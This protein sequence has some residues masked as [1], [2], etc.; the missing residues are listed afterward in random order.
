MKFP[1]LTAALLLP[2]PLPAALPLTGTGSHVESFDSLPSASTQEWIDNAPLPN[3]YLHRSNAAAPFPVTL[4]INDNQPASP[5]VAGIYSLGSTGST[6]RALGSAPTGTLGEVALILV[7]E[8]AG[9]LPLQITQIVWHAEKWREN[10]TAGI[11]ERIDFSWQKSLDEFSLISSFAGGWN[12][13]DNLSVTVPHS[14]I[15]A[16][17]QD[18]GLVFPVSQAPETPMVLE[19]GEYA[20]LRWLNLNESGSDAYLGIDNVGL[21][22][23]TVNGAIV[24]GPQNLTRETKGTPGPGDDTFSFT[25]PVTGIGSVSPAGWILAAPLPAGWTGPAGGAYGDEVTYSG[26]PATGPSVSLTLRDSASSTITR[27]VTIT[28]PPV[29]ADLTATSGPL[30]VRFSAPAPGS[31]S[32][33]RNHTD[34]LTDLGWTSNVPNNG[35]NGVSS[36]PGGGDPNRYFRL[37]NF[38]ANRFQTEAVNILGVAGFEV[39]LQLAA[40]TTSASGFEDSPAAAPVFGTSDRLQVVVEASGDGVNWTVASPSLVSSGQTAV[41]Q[42]AAFRLADPGTGYTPENVL[43]STL[44]NPIPFPATRTLRFTRGSAAFVRLVMVGGNDSNTENT[45]IDNIRFAAIPPAITA[46]LS[47]VIRNNLGDDNPANDTFTFSLAVNNDDP[48]RLL[49]W[50]SDVP[51]IAGPY[52]PV[53]V[54]FPDYPVS[55]GTVLIT[56]T[57]VEDAGQTLAYPVLVPDGILTAGIPV[58]VRSEGA[59]PDPADDTWSF[60]VAVTAVNAGTGYTN[61]TNSA[62]VAYG[63]P[64]TFGPWPVS[65]GSRTVIFRDRSDPSWTTTLTVPPPIRPVLATVSTG[66]VPGVLYS[67]VSPAI[68]GWTQGAGTGVLVQV[69]GGGTVPHVL[70]SDLLDLSGV[71]GAVSFRADFSAAETSATTNFET[72][73]TFKIE[74]DLVRPSGTTLLNVLTAAQDPGNGA[75]STG[76]N[77]PANGVLNGF[78][79]T[80]DTGAGITAPQ[81]YDANRERDEFNLPVNGFPATAA[82]FFTSTFQFSA[83]IPDDVT[84]VRLLVTGLNNSATE[85]FTVSGMRFD[86]ASTDPPDNDGD[87]ASNVDEATAGTDPDNPADVLRLAG[88]QPVAGSDPTVWRSRF[89]SKPGRFYRLYHSSDLQSWTSEGNSY[90]GDGGDFDVLTTPPAGTGRL[91]Y[92]LMVRLMDGFPPSTP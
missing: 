91:Y 30:E 12:P 64:V 21:S 27:T 28:T 29:P 3:W 58:R 37:N 72:N 88:F 17:V 33:S 31:A 35:T 1:L 14:G 9:T 54:D 62:S 36:R 55:G 25:L 7:V 83:L 86:L 92:R 69:N 6:D 84:A 85:S 71:S 67:A 81:D 78:T 41:E 4:Q 38:K 66:P 10:T 18:P 57:D 89:A 43:P 45:L 90:A 77:G 24:T 19:P 8:N 13:V 40:Y 74:L 70:R 50:T 87:G 15:A 52:S 5:W 42:F 56:L 49:G 47:N 39:S 60:S 63:T 32:F 44:P 23:T 75:P 34:G 22:W 59:T 51:G 2:V 82:D 11:V 68:T 53:P 46:S 16:A 79:G 80:A 20:A 48:G 76:P 65:T 61:D 73:D 26:I